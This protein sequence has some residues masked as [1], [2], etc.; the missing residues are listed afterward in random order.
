MKKLFFAAFIILLSIQTNAQSKSAHS[1][2]YR[3]ALGVKVWDGGG[4]SFKHFLDDHN[5]LELIGYF[6]NRGTRITGLYEIHGPINGAPG[7]QWYIGPGA[8]IGF[9]NTKNGDGAFAG[10]DG[11]LGLDYKFN[12]APINISLDWQPSF[13]FGTNRGF[14]GSWGGLGIRYTF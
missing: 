13:E 14:Y 7:L 8:H 4:I 3:T 1:S 5:A 6:W 9:Y 2:Q 10:V 12:G 11:V